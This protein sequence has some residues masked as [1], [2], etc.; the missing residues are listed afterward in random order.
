MKV[1]LV[2]CGIDY[3]EEEIAG[4][5]ATLSRALKLAKSRMISYDGLKNPGEWL[6]TDGHR[7]TYEDRYIMIQ[8]KEVLE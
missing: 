4:V 7:W 8:E 3:D 2:L 1:Y 5:C 6:Q